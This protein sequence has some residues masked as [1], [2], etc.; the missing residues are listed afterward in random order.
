M[1]Y[2]NFTNISTNSTFYQTLVRSIL[3]IESKNSREYVLSWISKNRENVQVKIEHTKFSQ[4]QQWFLDKEKGSYCHISGGFF[5]IDG[6]QVHTNY[7]AIKRWEQPI[8]N[9][10]EIGILGIITKN[11]NG[12]L[13]FLLQ[14]KIE[15]GNINTVQISPTLQATKSNYVKKH[16]GKTPKYLEYFQ[17]PAKNIILDQLQSEQGAR[18]LRKRNRNIIIY[19]EEEIPVEAEFCWMTLEQIWALSK[20]DNTVNMDTRTVL[21]GLQFG[22]IDMKTCTH[23]L[24][25]FKNALLYSEQSRNEMFSLEQI[26]SWLTDLKS[27]YE[28]TIDHKPLHT[29]QEWHCTDE[30]IVHVDKR[31]FEVIPVNVVISN[32]EVSMWDQ[33]MIRPC[34]SGICAFFIKKIE[35]TYHF[36]VQAKMECGNFDILELA[37]TIQCL[38]GSYKMGNVPYVK[39]LE[40]ALNTQSGV[41][42]DVFQ[43]EEGGRFFGEQNRNIVIEV[44]ASFEEIDNPRF[45]W[46]SLA[47]LKNFIRYN[48]Y[49]NIQARS[50]LAQL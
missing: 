31:Y 41:R 7:G 44:D 34:Q 19:V 27:N 14:A 47:Q 11:I 33:P 13:H 23:H 35:D 38:T 39:E 42:L 10:S 30:S 12:T 20:I 4:L 15:P 8:I 37:P 16:K 26:I 28:L 48:N 5:R 36:L 50:L 6:I 22:H 2:P 49:L 40:H 43:S 24:S 3:G 21:S 46:M 18:F 29:I 45:I 32:R 17:N 1:K 25:P 9:Q